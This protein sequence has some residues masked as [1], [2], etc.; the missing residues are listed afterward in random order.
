MSPE[1]PRRDFLKSVPAAAYA[2]TAAMRDPDQQ[3][4]SAPDGRSAVRRLEAFDYDGVTLGAGRWKRQVEL[5]R[6]FYFSVSDDDILHGFRAAAGLPAPGKPL[7]GWCGVDSGTV[8]GQWLSGMARLSRAT[9]DAALRDKAQRLLAEWTKTVPASGDSKLGH[10][11]FDK[12]VCGLVDLHLYAEDQYAIPALERV[13]AFAARNLQRMQLPLADPSHNQHYYGLPQEWYTLSENLYR[14]YR[15]TNAPELRAF[16][17]EWRYQAY[18]D[19]F[20]ASAMPSD[21]HGVHA[22]SHVNTFSSAAMAYGVSGDPKYLAT[23]KNAYEYLRQTQCYATGGYG[24]NERFMAPDGSLGRALETR[25]DTCETSCGSWAGFKLARYLMLF[26]GEARYGDWIERVFYNGIGAALPI[27]TG[28]R[29]FYYGDYRL[30]GGMK[31]YNWD[32]FTCCSG[33]YIQNVADYHNLIYFR[34]ADALYVNLFV[35]STVRWSRPSGVVTVVQETAY[36][37]AETTSLKISVEEP[38]TFALRIRVPTWTRGMTATVNGAATSITA[39]PGTWATID[40]TWVTGDRV[41]LHVPVTLRMESVD[42]QHP[43]RVAVMRG[44]VVLVLEGAYHDPNFRLPMRDDDLKAW[45]VAE[46]GTTQRGIWSVGQPPPEFPVT[47]FRVEPPDKKPVRLRFRPFYEVGE[48]YPY[49]M[50]FD[51][52]NLPWKLW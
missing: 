20:A 28:G 50:Y 49:F 12:V 9:G 27:T 32:T 15:V 51:R 30:G 4:K 31:V 10:Y 41:E 40:R 5:A 3:T 19:K 21:A 11:A 1:V 25:S 48:G 16:A 36:P 13:T 33:T 45:L 26:T 47:I 35:P 46:E 17:D 23:I 43:D 39:S 29:N 22:Y 8:F 37:D 7:G 34:D 2:V 52:K 42:A 44:P 18:W 6:D 24:P 14:A 38:T